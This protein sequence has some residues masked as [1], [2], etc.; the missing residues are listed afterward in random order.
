MSK[1]FIVTGA[2]RGLG[3]AVAQ[4][5]LRESHRVFVVARTEDGLR[6]LGDGDGDGDAVRYMCADLADLEVAPKIVARALKA[7]GRLDGLVINHSSLSPIAKISE[8]SA[9]DWRRAFDVNVFSALA[10]VKECIPELRKSNGRVIFVSSG[11][12]TSAY[13]GWGAYGTSK[14]ALNHLCAHLAVEEPSITSVIVSPGKVD[15][16]MQKQIRDEGHA[17][18]S[19]EVH[20]SFVAEHENGRLLNPNQPGTVIAKLAIGA[21]STLNGKHYRWNSPEL[22]HFQPE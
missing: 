7:F 13:I 18:M 2:S 19:P 3:L 17:S 8:S 9:E 14:A 11:A 16:A 5:L 10:L 15:T 20:A 21:T 6:G 12:S 4:A 22:A 1:T